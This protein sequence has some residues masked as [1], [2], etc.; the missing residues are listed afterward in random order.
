MIWAFLSRRFR[1]WVMFA[2]GVPLLRRLLG[3]AGDALEARRGES[4]L[5]RGMQGGGRYLS[6]YE[7]G[8]KRQARRRR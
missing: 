7:R 8:A 5:T 2:V 1:L 3:G 4:A 6:K